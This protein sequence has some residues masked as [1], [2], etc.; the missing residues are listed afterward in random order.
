MN[1]DM[2]KKIIHI[3]CLAMALAGSFLTI[4]VLSNAGVH[5]GFIIDA[6]LG[7]T[8]AAWI[9]YGSLLNY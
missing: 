9:L 6:A 4:S 8:A 3:L 5:F 1:T 7:F 2:Q